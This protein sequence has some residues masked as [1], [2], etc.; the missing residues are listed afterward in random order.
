MKQLKFVPVFLAVVAGISLN[1]QA[2]FLVNDT[3]QDA[4]RSDAGLNVH[5]EQGVDTDADLNIESRWFGNPPAGLTSTPG[6]ML[7]AVGA[8][9][10][11]SWTTYFT[12]SFASSVNLANA[13]D[14]LK[15]TWVF[16]PTG[17]TASNNSQGLRLALLQTPNGGRLATDNTPANQAYAGY[18]LFQSFGTVLGRNNGDNF[19]LMEW[20]T[21]GG[22]NNILS[23][24]AAYTKRAGD[25]TLGAV[26]FV[27]NTQYTFTM[28]AQRTAL[29]ELQLNTSMTG[30][31]IN[32]SGT[33]AA[34]FLD[35]TPSSFTFDT[36][37]LRP[38]SAAIS[39][40]TFDTSL[41]SVEVTQAPEPN[42]AALM[43]LSI[44][45]L[46]AARRSRL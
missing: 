10:S 25:G 8:S 30:G 14:T 18:G 21:P 43:G 38:G 19:N 4:N 6:H 35:T 16:T 20:A 11:A 42:V 41:F 33:L 26:G 24:G 44:M 1:S 29:G 22:A 17:V 27:D 12:E 23:T 34:S 39:A 45:G 5:S 46:I 15:V 7:G 31:S 40:A 28:T 32:G 2:A 36:F 13:G 37:A 3:F 9:S